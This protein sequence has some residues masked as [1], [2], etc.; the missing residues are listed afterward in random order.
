M[1]H[2]EEDSSRPTRTSGRKRATKELRPIS[3]V[4][5]SSIPM[6]CLRDGTV[7]G[8][9]LYD[10][11]ENVQHLQCPRCGEIVKVRIQKSPRSRQPADQ[12]PWL[13]RDEF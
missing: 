2:E 7:D 9:I 10:R 13:L 5:I 6:N 11:G 1:M 12:K 8:K 4:T 3:E